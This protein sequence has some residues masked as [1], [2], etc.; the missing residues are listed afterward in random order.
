M[1]C[2]VPRARAVRHGPFAEIALSESPKSRN[3]TLVIIETSGRADV[4][5]TSTEGWRRAGSLQLTE[6]TVSSAAFDGRRVFW[7]E[8]G[9]VFCR[10][11]GRRSGR[12]RC[13]GCRWTR[14]RLQRSAI[15]CAASWWSCGRVRRRR[16]PVGRQR[17]RRR[18]RGWSK[19][20]IRLCRRRF[21]APRRSRRT[22]SWLDRA[23]RARRLRVLLQQ[24]H[25]CEPVGTPHG[26]RLSQ[27]VF[28][29]S[30]DGSICARH[31]PLS[32]VIA[33]RFSQDRS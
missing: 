6:G 12:W 19:A 29:G 26:A 16:E 23:Y 1:A 5:C 11:L 32:D 28:H 24:P 14:I 17:P 9:G 2:A 25:G 30:L 31:R 21:Q 27:V 13:G 33:R 10:A 22:K 4:W 15:R 18:R 20:R 3:A 8:T 7:R